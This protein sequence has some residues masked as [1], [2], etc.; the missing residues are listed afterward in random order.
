MNKSNEMRYRFDAVNLRRTT[1]TEI[2][3]NDKLTKIKRTEKLPT[4]KRT[5][6]SDKRKDSSYKSCFCV[7]GILRSSNTH[8]RLSA[9][10]S[11]LGRAPSCFTAHEF[12]GSRVQSPGADTVNQAVHPSGV[13]KLVATSIQWVT[14]VEDCGCK[15]VLPTMDG[16]G[17]CC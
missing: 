2:R 12:D 16:M 10:P 14:A 4:P 7:C 1:I 13:G 8:T 9:W 3:R 6:R 15:C 17:L 5:F 11:G